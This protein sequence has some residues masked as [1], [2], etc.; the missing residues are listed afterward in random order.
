M[1]EHLAAEQAQTVHDFLVGH[2]LTGAHE[3]RDLID[4]GFPPALQGLDDALGVSAAE[5]LRDPGIFTVVEGAQTRP[6]GVACL[7]VRLGRWC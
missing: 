4:A 6:L 1:G 2:Y 3:E 7:P 5:S